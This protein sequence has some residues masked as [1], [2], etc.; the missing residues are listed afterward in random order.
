M[1]FNRRGCVSHQKHIEIYHN[2]KNTIQAKPK[3]V[4]EKYSH[5]TLLY[6]R[7][8]TNV[9]KRVYSQRL[10]ISYTTTY[11]AAG[12][13]QTHIYNDRR[14]YRKKL[15]T[16][17]PYHSG[18]SKTQKRQKSRFERACRSIFH[19]RGN[20]IRARTPITNIDDQ[21]HRARQHR[22]LFLPS[23]YIYKPL[24]HVKHH[25]R[26]VLREAEHY[27]FPIPS[28]LPMIEPGVITN[29]YNLP[30]SLRQDPGNVQ[31]KLKGKQHEPGSKGWLDAFYARKN[32]QESVDAFKLYEDRL[33][34]RAK[35]WGTSANSIEYREGMVKDLSAFQDHYHQKI[36]ALTDR[37]LFLH[38]KIKRGKSVHKT[39]QQLVKLE[40]ELA[41]FKIDYFSVMDDN[42]SHYRYKGHTSDDTKELEFRPNKRITP[43]STGIS[44]SHDHI[45]KARSALLIKE[46]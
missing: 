19:N 1:S 6:D 46:D 34:A 36:T 10:G 17:I 28:I 5:A 7:W 11:T 18:Q 24:Q 32:H 23:Q 21:L 8:D 30:P 31:E 15:D 12:F 4:N 20:N 16:F 39:N 14:M 22:F 40:K 35:L 42:A 37:Q 45:K 29:I 25:K 3:F 9:K 2:I 43:S 44:R 13:K 41:Q 38:D 33:S 26:L 27:K